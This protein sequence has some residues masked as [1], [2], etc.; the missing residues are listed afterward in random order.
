MKTTKLLYIVY[1]FIP[2]L[3]LSSG[4]AQEWTASWHL[5]EGANARLGKGRLTNILFSDDGT[6]VAV[7]TP[8]GIWVYDVQTRDAVSLFREIQTGEMTS[9]FMMSKKPPEIL[10]FSPD[11]VRIASAHGNRVYVWDTETGT[12]F[13]MLDEHPAAITAL[14]LSPD[15]TK[16]ATASGDWTVHVWDV[17][18]GNYLNNLKGHSSAVNAVA[19]SPDSK[20]LASAGSTLRMWDVDTGELLHADPKDLGSTTRLVFSPEGKIVASGG[21][22]D[23]TVYLWE[24]GTGALQKALKGHTSSLRDIAFSS[25]GSTLVSVDSTGMRLWDVDTGIELKKLP[26]PQDKLPQPVPSI[27]KGEELAQAYLPWHR[28][29]VRSV[30]FSQDGKRI[31]TVSRDGSLHVWDIET[32]VY[33]LS[34]SLGE[35]TGLVSVLTFS[36]DGRY[37]AS[38]DGFAGRVRVWNVANATQ[39]AILTPRGGGL[40]NYISDLTISAGIKKLAGRDSQGT[41]HVWDAATLE[42]VSAIP[43]DRMLPYWP[44]LFSP[45]GKILAGRGGDAQLRN[46]IELWN[47]D[48]GAHQSTL[49]SPT[50]AMTAYAFSPDGRILVSGTEPATLVLWDAQTGK[51]LSELAGH[52]TR[53]RVIAFSRDGT[54]LASGSGHEV[55][56]WDVRTGGLVSTLKGLANV[57]TLAFSPDRETLASGDEKGRIHIYELSANYEVQTAFSGHEGSIN[58]LRFSPDGKTLASG[59]SDGTILL[60]NIDKTPKGE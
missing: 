39:H 32:G 20:I 46:K 57:R 58:V 26:A 30:R 59:S 3:L 53:I 29:D 27:L 41:I 60:W 40:L 36:Q 17:R 44:L 13:A 19:F 48:A 31:I 4:F 18:T 55:R 2:C 49:E 5:P 21:A 1:L 24:V 37:L 54:T 52:T 56:L 51:R 50:G 10:A 47:T 35:H 38:N 25:E 34:F 14:A 23:P 15:N 6:R 22:W 42:L 11:A 8:I 7:S 16:L 28:D 33:L 9:G 45:G 12:A 43:A